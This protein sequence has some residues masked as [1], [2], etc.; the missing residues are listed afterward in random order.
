MRRQALT[1]TILLSAASLL[2]GMAD[3][4]QSD[5]GGVP[6]QIRQVQSEVT[7]LQGQVNNLQGQITTIQGND[8]A[9]TSAISSLTAQISQLQTT[10]NS[11]GRPGQALWTYYETTEAFTVCGQPNADPDG[12]DVGG[13]GDNIIRLVNPNGAANGNLAG[14]KP[15]T[16][17]AMIYVFN[18]D[19]EMG[20]CCGC[21][22]S[23]AGL[24]TFSVSQ[25]LT[26]NWALLGGPH[27]GEHDNGAI[28]I[29][30]AAQNPSL[31][32]AGADSNGQ[33]CSVGQS[34][35]CNFE[36]DPTN[37]PGYS[38][39]TANNLLGTITHNQEVQGDL[40]P[41]ITTGLTEVSLSDDGHGDPTNLTYLQQ[42]CGAIVGASSGG[43]ICDCPV[44]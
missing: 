44:E 27:N 4:A 42:Q 37:T 21:P 10:L 34:K 31:I 19:Q 17:C 12:C 23:S 24:A 32:G 39:T 38:V 2:M 15:Q 18:D 43:G 9:L 1:A 40:A 20:E 6:G 3:P 28:A 30:A 26:G 11:F 5:P 14:A 16:V 25:Y 35:A 33:A 29:V 7:T 8:S 41:G 36:C 13:N 22:I